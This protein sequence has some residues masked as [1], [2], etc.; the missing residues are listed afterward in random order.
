MDRL[1]MMKLRMM[2][3]LGLLSVQTL[4]SSIKDFT[5]SS[6]STLNNNQVI[7]EQ[8][9]KTQLSFSTSSF[10]HLSAPPYV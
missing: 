2:E 7:S 3:S 4:Q 10:T 6:D 5:D 8:P 1:K 9:L